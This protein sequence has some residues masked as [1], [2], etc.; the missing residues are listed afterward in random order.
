MICICPR[1]PRESHAVWQPVLLSLWCAESVLPAAA[2]GSPRAEQRA[3]KKIK[4]QKQKYLLRPISPP[5]FTF[6]TYT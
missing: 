1:A 6:D 4:K 5:W 2:S 3:G